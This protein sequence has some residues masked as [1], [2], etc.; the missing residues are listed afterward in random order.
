[1]RT[2]RWSCHSQNG[3]VRNTHV[4][5]KFAVN[6]TVNRRGVDLSKIK[7]IAEWEVEEHED[8]VDLAAR[9]E[10]ALQFLHEHRA[11]GELIYA[12]WEAIQA[13]QQWINKE[14][15]VSGSS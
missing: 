12:V 8:A 11:N 2:G 9:L 7:E 13:N 3:G 5:P 4:R 15:L 1:M 10:R 6:Q 14:L